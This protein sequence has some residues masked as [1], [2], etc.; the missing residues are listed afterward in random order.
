MINGCIW[1]INSQIY[2]TPASVGHQGEFREAPDNS[3][4]R[5]DRLASGGDLVVVFNGPAGRLGDRE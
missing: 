4:S 1:D 2:K 3:R 5:L